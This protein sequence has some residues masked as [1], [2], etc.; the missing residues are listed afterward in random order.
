MINGCAPVDLERFVWEL[1]LLEKH[2]ESSE[3]CPRALFEID[4]IHRR[5]WRISIQ[6][7][8][9]FIERGCAGRLIN[10]RRQLDLFVD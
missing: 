8:I 3:G 1:D 9:V 7:K 4:P 6:R 10:G 5:Y 2:V